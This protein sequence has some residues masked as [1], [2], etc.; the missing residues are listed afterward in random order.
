MKYAVLLND[1]D[2]AV[3][4]YDTRI[5]AEIAMIEMAKHDKT[6]E[7]DTPVTEALRYLTEKDGAYGIIPIIGLDRYA[8]ENVLVFEEI[9]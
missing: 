1:G 2:G 6:I 9:K 8:S 3:G 7:K 5:E 4:I